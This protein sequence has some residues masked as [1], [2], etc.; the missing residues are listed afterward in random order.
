[1]DTGSHGERNGATPPRTHRADAP[2]G[3]GGANSTGQPHHPHRAK[4][5]RLAALLWRL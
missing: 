1:M 4:I 3:A 2:E 5:G